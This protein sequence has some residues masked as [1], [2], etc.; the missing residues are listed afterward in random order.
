MER[1]QDGGLLWQYVSWPYLLPDRSETFT[2]IFNSVAAV[3]SE[4]S[5]VVVT[6]EMEWVAR[7]ADLLAR[8]RARSIVYVRCIYTHVI[9]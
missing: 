5:N 7:I 8:T 1:Q 9:I 2:D 4:R 6:P 3:A